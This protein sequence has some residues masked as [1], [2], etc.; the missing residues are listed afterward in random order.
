MLRPLVLDDGGTPRTMVNK[1]RGAT[2]RRPT[3]D[4]PKT[5]R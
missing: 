4:N 1:W 3:I 5:V 2:T